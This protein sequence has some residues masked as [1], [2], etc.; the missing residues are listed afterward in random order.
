MFSEPQPQQDA[1]FNSKLKDELQPKFNEIL[2][3]ITKEINNG[4][5]VFWVC[6]LIEESTF[7]D[8]TSAK[9]KFDII[10]DKFPNNVGLIHGALDKNEKE[11]ILKRFLKS[12]FR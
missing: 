5:Q 1:S 8:Y 12:R 11:H 3:F 10:N 2:K 6:P 4:N 9:K 7:L